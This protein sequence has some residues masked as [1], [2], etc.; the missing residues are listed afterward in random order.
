MADK[1]ELEPK[2]EA[3]CQEYI[4]D[5]NASQAAIRAGYSEKASRSVA[6]RMLT[7]AN[8]SDRINELIQKRKAKVELTADL[9]LAEILKLAQVD[10]GKAYDSNGNLLPIHEIPEDVRK[11]MSGVKVFE[12]FEGVG[13]DRIKIGEVREVKFWDKTKALELLGKHLKL[14]TDRIEHSGKLTMAELVAGSIRKE[15]ERKN[16]KEN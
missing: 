13:R 2:Q 9:I 4:K 10:L 8:I 12:E 7:K 1:K 16:D 14:F 6:S 5:F 11:A 15:K 3:F